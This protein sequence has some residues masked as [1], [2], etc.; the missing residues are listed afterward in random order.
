[1]RTT[2]T[3]ENRLAEQLK[4]IAHADGKSFKQV[5]NETLR[6]GLRS[7]GGPARRAP[8]KLKP[9][10]LGEPRPGYNLDKALSLAAELENAEIAD[11]LALRK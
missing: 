6:A 1:M 8:Y 7:N 3:L 4:A 11:K 5:V 10:N 9:V 2:L